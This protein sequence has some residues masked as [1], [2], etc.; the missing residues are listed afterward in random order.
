MSSPVPSSTA[1]PADTV[2]AAAVNWE[3]VWRQ[4]GITL[5]FFF[6]AG[7]LTCGAPPKI[8]ASAEALA[9]FYDGNRIRI[10]IAVF[11]FGN[12]LLNLLWFAATIASTLRQSG[13]G[14]WGAAATAS[15]AVVGGAFLL[16]LTIGT[17]LA[18]SIGTSGQP[19]LASG[20]NDLV[21]VG[22]VLSSFPRA[23]LVMAGSFGL[24]RAGL[25]SNALFAAGVAAVVLVLLG[26]TTWIGDGVWAPD[27]VYS[28]LICPVINL[29]W[30]GAAG[31]VMTRLPA[32][33]GEW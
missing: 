3:R 26:G 15:S 20:L 30:F 33:R 13:Q 23:M 28:R 19:A 17:G 1:M 27:G 32:T 6:I 31:I 14:G 22:L 21:W 8:G 25:I 16:L 24:W 12:A 18:Y 2:N 7:Y 9:A 11:L 29:A 5:V 4:N 10:F